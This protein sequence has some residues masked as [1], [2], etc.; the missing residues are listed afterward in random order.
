MS[1]VPNGDRAHKTADASTAHTTR[2]ILQSLLVNIAIAGIKAV[3]A[4][5]TG[6]GAMLAESIHSFADCANQVLL[7]IGVRNAKLPADSRHP[8]GYGR[9]AYFWSFLVAQMLFT[10]GGVFS[11]YEGVH[12]FLE[13]EPVS[14]VLVALLILLASLVLEGGALVSNILELNKRRGTTPFV[15]YLRETKDVD[16]IVVFAENGAAVLGLSVAA[17]ALALAERT[18]DGRWD[19]LGSFAIGLILVGVASFLAVE[20]KSL[21][22]GEAADP[23]IERVAR[24]AAL[25]TPS[26]E[27]VLHVLTVQQGP[28]EVVLAIK[29][30]FES[31]LTIDDV[32]R[33]INAFEAKVRD[34]RRDVRWIFVEPDIPRD[35]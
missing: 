13:P 18:G 30:A 14:H 3:A 29:L 16:L 28:G 20:A 33:A 26:V 6:S 5:M 9:D 25:S 12:K 34:A 35:P 15:R 8:L 1:S 27:R 32:C 31:G 7:L 2:H 21:L 17:G 4:V 11:I 10:G 19:A 23:D 22:V 24:T